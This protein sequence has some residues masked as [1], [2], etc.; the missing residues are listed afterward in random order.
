MKIPLDGLATLFM[1]KGE[2]IGHSGSTGSL[3]FYYPEKDMF[4]LEMSIKW[5]TPQFLCG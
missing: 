1:G 5:K 2:L 3:A 4:L